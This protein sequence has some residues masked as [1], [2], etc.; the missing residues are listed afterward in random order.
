MSFWVCGYFWPPLYVLYLIPGSSNPPKS[1]PSQSTVQSMAYY[2]FP[3]N[4]PPVHST[5]WYYYHTSI[6]AGLNDKKLNTL[7]LVLQTSIA[8]RVMHGFMCNKILIINELFIL[9]TWKNVKK[10]KFIL[11]Y[12]LYCIYVPY[13]KPQRILK[14]TDKG[15]KNI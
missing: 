6:I 5:P 12:N 8:T 4:F 2:L 13:L 9:V 1:R 11:V 10:I 3:F 14:N 7:K 15:H